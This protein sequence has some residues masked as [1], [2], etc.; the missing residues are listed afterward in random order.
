MT[1]L[2][3]AFNTSADQAG[4]LYEIAPGP[5]SE[6]VGDYGVLIYMC[7]VGFL[8]TMVSLALWLF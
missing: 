3:G 7:V 6:K 8:V 4:L 2:E 5:S 1:R